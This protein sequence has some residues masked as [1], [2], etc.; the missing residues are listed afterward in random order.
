LGRVSF[1]KAAT[2][3]FEKNAVE[4]VLLL[5]DEQNRLVGVRPITK[6][7]NRAYK[8]HFGKKGNG[9]GFSAATFLTYIRYDLSESRSILA[10]WDEQEQMFVIEV[11]QE[12]L[13]K[14][15]QR[16]VAT[17]DKRRTKES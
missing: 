15:I 9:A 17:K 16:P 12:Y 3:L 1:N 14:D 5:W 2:A 11:P 13:G 8:L 6:K 7:D 10:R 4:N